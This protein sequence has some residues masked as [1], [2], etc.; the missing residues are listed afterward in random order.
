MAATNSASSLVV[1]PPR[2]AM[3]ELQSMERLAAELSS[4]AERLRQQFLVADLVDCADQLRQIEGQF[5]FAR[6]QVARLRRAA[7]PPF[8]GGPRDD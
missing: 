8:A 6:D 3:D 5:A 1:F 2:G 7:F 4:R